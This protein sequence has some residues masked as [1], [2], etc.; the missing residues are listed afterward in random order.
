MVNQHAREEWLV[1]RLCRHHPVA[2][3]GSGTLVTRLHQWEEPLRGSDRSIAMRIHQP[4]HIRYPAVGR[5][6]RRITYEVC[7]N[8]SGSN[9]SHGGACDTSQS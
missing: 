5:R 3:L 6:G 9:S 7:C 4:G 2:I 8:N 1:G